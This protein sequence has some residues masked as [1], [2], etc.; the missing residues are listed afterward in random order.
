MEE[1]KKQEIERLGLEIA[2]ILDREGDP[3][4]R[5]EITL[6][7]VKVMS[8]DSFCPRKKSVKND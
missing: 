3:Y 4:Q 7:G 2:E 1:K 5:V 6:E 8:T